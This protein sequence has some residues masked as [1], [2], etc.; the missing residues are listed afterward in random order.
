MQQ[1]LGA[2]VVIEQGHRRTEL[3]Q[4]QP[5]EHEGGLVPHEESHRVS[6]P[7]AGLTLERVRDL[8]APSVGLFVRVALVPEH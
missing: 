7:V 2:D 5:G 6:S 8:I 3:S 4:G 1:R